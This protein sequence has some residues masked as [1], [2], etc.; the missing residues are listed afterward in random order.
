MI[1]NFPETFLFLLEFLKIDILRWK[2][3]WTF[4]YRNP[5]IFQSKHGWEMSFICDKKYYITP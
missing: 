1:P 3:E 5:K 4:F 2:K